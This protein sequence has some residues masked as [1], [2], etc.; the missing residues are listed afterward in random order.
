MM[1]ALDRQRVMDIMADATNVIAEGEVLQ[2]MN[3]HDPTP[4][5]S[6][7]SM[8]STARPPS[9]SRPAPRSPRCS[10]AVHPRMRSARSPPTAGISAP[11]ISS[12]TTCSTTAPIPSERGKN[13]GDDLAE[14][15]PTLPLIYALRNGTAAQ[16]AAIRDA[17]RKGGLAHLEP[18]IAA[19]ESTG[20][21][22]YAARRAGAECDAALATLSALPDSS[23]KEGLAALARFAVEHTT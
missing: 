21:L 1:A 2:L 13:L 11:P 10:P 19:I 8:S 17:I 5:R 18:M 3:A 9:C 4:P 23:Y 15:K 6:A 20:G 16:R 7:T 12:S 14:G 22:E